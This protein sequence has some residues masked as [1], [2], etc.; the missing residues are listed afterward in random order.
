MKIPLHK[1][2][3]QITL[4]KIDENLHI[5]LFSQIFISYGEYEK[6]EILNYTPDEKQHL[7]SLSLFHI[8]LASSQ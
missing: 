3:S 2:P 1:I 5:E 4:L 6:I 7:P 8:Q